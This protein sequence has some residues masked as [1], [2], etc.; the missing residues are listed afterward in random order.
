MTTHPRRSFLSGRLMAE[1]TDMA[2]NRVWIS[3]PV[4]FPLSFR[5]GYHDRPVNALS[6]LEAVVRLRDLAHGSTL[7]CTEGLRERKS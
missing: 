1:R 2:E 3:D 5:V 7:P 6:I 4:C